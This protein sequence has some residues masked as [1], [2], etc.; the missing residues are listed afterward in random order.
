MCGGNLLEVAQAL[1]SPLPS[2]SRPAEPTPPVLSPA[3][4]AAFLTLDAAMKQHVESALARTPGRV[5][6]LQCLIDE[7]ERVAAIDVAVVGGGSEQH[8]GQLCR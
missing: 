5:E 1:G 3:T 6:G 7:I 8:V 4:P 2:A